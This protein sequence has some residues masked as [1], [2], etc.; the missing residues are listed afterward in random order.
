MSCVSYDWHIRKQ[1]EWIR[2]TCF[3][4]V[5]FYSIL[6]THRA[7]YQLRRRGGRRRLHVILN[8]SAWRLPVLCVTNLHIVLKYATVNPCLIKRFYQWVEEFYKLS[9]EWFRNSAF[10][11]SATKTNKGNIYEPPVT[12]TVVV[13]SWSRKLSSALY[14]IAVISW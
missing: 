8:S 14:M 3:V 12:R 1:F 2:A 9:S 4:A 5:L 11:Y 6:Y 7:S 13:L 10:S